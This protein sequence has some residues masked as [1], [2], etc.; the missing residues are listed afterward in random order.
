MERVAAGA[1]ITRTMEEEKETKEEEG[2]RKRKRE[3]RAVLIVKG[4]RESWSPFQ[5]CSIHMTHVY[6]PRILGPLP[7]LSFL[8]LYSLSGKKALTEEKDDGRRKRRIERKETRK[9]WDQL[10]QNRTEEERIE[11][12][13]RWFYYRQAKLEKDLRLFQ[14]FSPS[15]SKWIWWREEGG[16]KGTDLLCVQH[17]SN[18]SVLLTREESREQEIH[19][20]QVLRKKVPSSLLFSWPQLCSLHPASQTLK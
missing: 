14:F 2:D 1:A 8:P 19:F 17:G 10:G 6:E 3:E 4:R 15:S 20:G 11:A 9:K 12:G 5:P 7:S 13:R 16:E 18:F